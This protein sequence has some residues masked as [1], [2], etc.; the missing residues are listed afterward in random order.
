MP[1]RIPSHLADLLAAESSAPREQAWQQFVGQ[2]SR[3]VFSVAKSLGGTYDESMDRYAFILEQLKRADCKRL[4]GYTPV[5]HAKFTTWLVA[6][7]RRL[8]MDEYRNKYGRAR[9]GSDVIVLQTRRSLAQ[10]LLAT[11]ELHAIA[12]PARAADDDLETRELHEQL[13]RCL[14]ELSPADRLLIKLRFEDGLSAAEIAPVLGIPTAF[15]VY[16]RLKPLLARLRVAL[17]HGHPAAQTGGARPLH[18]A[19]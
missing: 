9:S 6:V 2:Y 16:R 12:S 19:E 8:C 10:S 3:L 18:V 13:T 15:H 11:R 1:D 14:D 17:T 4:R 7:C 5:A